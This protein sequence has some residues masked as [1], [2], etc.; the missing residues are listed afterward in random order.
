MV[1]FLTI[2]QLAASNLD[3]SEPTWWE[4]VCH[5]HVIFFSRPGSMLTRFGMITQVYDELLIIVALFTIFT[6]T[7]QIK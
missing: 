3:I 2:K 1:D 7:D 4:K 5:D 6:K